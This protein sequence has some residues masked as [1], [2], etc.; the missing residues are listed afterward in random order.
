[1][2]LEKTLANLTGTIVRRE[3]RKFLKL[4]DSIDESAVVGK[5]TGN[6]EEVS[7][8]VH[9]PFCRTLCPFCCF[10]RY[11]FQEDKARSYFRS[12]KKEVDFYS[13]GLPFFRLLFR[14]RHADGDDG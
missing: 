9:I 4:S 3:G 8:Y 7:L 11:L 13:E 5:G 12:L 10:N 1:M 14:W 2:S 6:D